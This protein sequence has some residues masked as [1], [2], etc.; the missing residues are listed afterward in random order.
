M[1]VRKETYISKKEYRI[2]LIT[3]FTAIFTF[4]KKHILYLPHW[5]KKLRM[6]HYLLDV[7]Y[8]SYKQESAI[9]IL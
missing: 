6:L 1:V 8:L 3:V 4:L 7:S 9:L 2:S 5:G